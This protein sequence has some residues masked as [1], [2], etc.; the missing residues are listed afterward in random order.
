M[1]KR[2]EPSKKSAKEKPAPKPVKQE[3]ALLTIDLAQLRASH[4]LYLQ[5]LLTQYPGTLPLEIS[6]IS[7]EQEHATI[8]FDASKGIKIDEAL[9]K[10][11]TSLTSVLK[12]EKVSN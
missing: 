12:V 5:N 3:M 10:D 4:I 2:Y 9:K 8:S 1:R 11:L 7:N 6:F